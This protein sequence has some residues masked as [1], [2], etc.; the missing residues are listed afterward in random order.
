VPKHDAANIEKW[1]ERQIAIRNQM[2][3]VDKAKA[4]SVSLDEVKIETTDKGEPICTLYR[5]KLPTMAK[6]RYHEKVSTLHQEN[7]AKKEAA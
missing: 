7:L 6:L 3:E 1:T 5:R 4:M 2:K